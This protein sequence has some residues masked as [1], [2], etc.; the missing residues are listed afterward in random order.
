MIPRPRFKQK[1]TL[2]ERLA[3]FASIARKKASLLPAGAEKDGL[4]RK[5]HQAD[6]SAHLADW[7]GS[8]GLQP[9]K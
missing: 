7:C 6:A 4:L 2:R 8:P 9:P 5:A 3:N 1:L